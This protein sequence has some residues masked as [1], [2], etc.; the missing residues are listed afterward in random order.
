[1]APKACIVVVHDLRDTAHQF[2]VT[3]ETTKWVVRGHD[4]VGD[5]GTGLTTVTVKI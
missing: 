4:W 3:A 2:Q 5:I 1:V